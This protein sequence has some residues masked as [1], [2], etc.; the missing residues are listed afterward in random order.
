MVLRR[1]VPPVPLPRCHLLHHQPSGQDAEGDHSLPRACIRTVLITPP[2]LE[3]GLCAVRVARSVVVVVVVV[4][5]FPGFRF[6]FLQAIHDTCILLLLVRGEPCSRLS[7][8]YSH[9]APLLPVVPKY[10]NACFT[11][12]AV[13]STG[14]E[15]NCI[16]GMHASAARPQ[17]ESKQKKTS[18]SPV[19]VKTE[20]GCLFPPNN[21]LLLHGSFH[22][23]TGLSIY[24][25]KY[26]HT[27][28]SNQVAKVPK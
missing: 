6:R 26:L 11:S 4:A 28:L 5:A 15:S 10:P 19:G 9:Q 1:V 24:G 25:K 27:Y 17:C 2:N 16:L 14:H 8:S 20:K 23:T 13:R 22:L 12:C 7:E 18:V 3:R 21:R